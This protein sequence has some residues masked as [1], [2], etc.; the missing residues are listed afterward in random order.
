[1]R[2]S[3][4]YREQADHARLLATITVQHNVAEVLSHAAEEFDRLA[5]ETTDRDGDLIDELD[6]E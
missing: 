2:R 6:K 3:S 4:Y 5:D 1:M